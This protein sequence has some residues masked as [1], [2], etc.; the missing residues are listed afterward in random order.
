MN[1]VI[2]GKSMRGDWSQMR[3]L[4]TLDMRAEAQSRQAKGYLKT[5]AEVINKKADKL[6]NKS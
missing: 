3:K 5:Q 6:A 2:T 1:T 4:Q